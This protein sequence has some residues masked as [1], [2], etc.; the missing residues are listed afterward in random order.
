VERTG[1]TT[2]SRRRGCALAPVDLQAKTSTDCKVNPPSLACARA[3]SRLTIPAGQGRLH[4]NAV[5]VTVTADLRW[6]KTWRFWQ[7]TTDARRV[8]SPAG[9]A[10][11]VGYLLIASAR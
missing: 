11:R 2:I 6:F 10:H 8:G 3:D 4:G 9:L 7:F 5:H 1:S